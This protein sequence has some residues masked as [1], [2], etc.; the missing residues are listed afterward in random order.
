MVSLMIYFMN[1]SL[2]EQFPDK[3]MDEELISF[4]TKEL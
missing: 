2:L 4:L 3:C 1:Q